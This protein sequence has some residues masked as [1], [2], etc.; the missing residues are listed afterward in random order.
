MSALALSFWI[1]VL[2]LGGILLGTLLRR[3]LPQRHLSKDTQDVVR[4]GVGLIATIAALVL[5]LLIAAAKSSFDTQST[6]VKQITADIILLD[7]LLAQYGPEALPIREQMRA[8]IGP[9][10]DRLW[11]EKKVSA[12]APF[13]FNASGEK[14]YLE[15]QALSP[16]NDLQRSLQARAAQL[17]TDLAQTRLLLFVET[18]NLIPTPF[19]AIL[20]F[21]LVIIFASFSL[22]SPLNV[23]VFTCLSL[24]ALSASGAIFLILELSQPF[25]GLMM[26]S[27][28]SLR[29]AL[30][31]L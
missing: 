7:N 9:F 24:F 19:L 27:S 16:Q 3:A 4:L 31:P 25:S 14:I 20:V 13:E 22:F 12:T 6:Q 28:A 5:G 26:I 8:A 2:T 18:D 1:F 29:N 15:I 21:W 30:G 11:R 10:V 17:S 23:T